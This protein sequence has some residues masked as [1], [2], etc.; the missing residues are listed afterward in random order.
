M[1]EVVVSWNVLICS[2]V[3]EIK[4]GDKRVFKTRYSWIGKVGMALPLCEV[5]R[6]QNVKLCDEKG[7]IALVVH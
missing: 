4:S 2:D 5:I 7:L 3:M 6:E 1:N